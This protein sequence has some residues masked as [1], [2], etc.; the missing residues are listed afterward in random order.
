[1]QAELIKTFH[2]DAAHALPNIPAG[3]KCRQLHGHSYRVDIH[4]TGE[5]D[6]SVGWVID[7]GEIKKHVGPLI[8][9]LDHANLNEI[10][11]LENST[12]ELIARF[13]WDRLKGSLPDLSAVTVWESE[14]AR[15]IYRGQ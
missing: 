10:P 3:H 7:F 9:E 11:G 6:E 12:S 1:M 2:F 13:F 4:I 15:C 8:E 5:V 14:T